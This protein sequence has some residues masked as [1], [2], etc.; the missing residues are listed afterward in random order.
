MV[1]PTTSI[2]PSSDD[3]NILNSFFCT[4]S[5]TNELKSEV[6]SQDYLEIQDGP[7]FNFCKSAKEKTEKR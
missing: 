5:L 1:R 3:N 7:S 2:N 4:N 6:E